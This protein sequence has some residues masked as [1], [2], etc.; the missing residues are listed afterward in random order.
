MGEGEGHPPHHPK[1]ADAP[2]LFQPAASSPATRSIAFTSTPMLR[3]YSAIDRCSWGVWSSLLSPGPYATM[4]QF[5]SGPSTFMSLVPVFRHGR[6]VPPRE[7]IATEKAR[8][9]TLLRSLAHA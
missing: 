2:V 5:H 9:S 4:G 6:G 3:R 8:T 7:R 1:K